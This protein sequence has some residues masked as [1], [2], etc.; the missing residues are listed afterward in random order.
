M[1]SRRA[2]SR[3]VRKRTNANTTVVTRSPSGV[4]R[5][6]K[7]VIGQPSVRLLQP[8]TNA[9]RNIRRL[10]KN[11]PSKGIQQPEARQAMLTSQAVVPGGVRVNGGAPAGG[12]RITSKDKTPAPGRGLTRVRPPRLGPLKRRGNAT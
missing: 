3:S 12:T 5:L 6:A 7:G 8:G 1:A 9:Y 2:R 4:R 10:I 11:D